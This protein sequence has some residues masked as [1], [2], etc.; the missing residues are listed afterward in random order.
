MKLFRNGK[1]RGIRHV[2]TPNVGFSY[3]P[4]FGAPPFNYY[5]RT[6]LDTSANYSYLS[7]YQTS[8]V[9]MPPNGKSGSINMALNNN[10]QIKVRSAKDTVS[11]YRNV[12]L[13]D[14]LGVSTAYNMAVDSFRWSPL[15]LNFRTNIADKVNISANASYDPYQIDYSNGRRTKELMI[16]QG[17]GIAR[18]TNASLSLGSNLH[19]KPKSGAASPTNSEEYGRIA[20]SGYYGDYVDFNVPWSMNVSYSLSM[21][22]NYSTFSKKDTIVFTHNMVFQGEVNLTERWKINVSSGYDFTNKQLTLTSIDLYRDLHCWQM[23]MQTIPFGPR[24]S[25]NFTLNVKATVLQDLKLLRR[26]DYR[27]A[28]N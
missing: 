13:I 22:N 17:N 25:Y 27:D 6:H 14:G 16:D 12:T 21:N 9:G 11:G 1:L 2:L 19:S 3:H 15:A 23:H 26:R 28:A 24:K 7:P 20:R 10:L 5:Y 8:I 18:F 4:D